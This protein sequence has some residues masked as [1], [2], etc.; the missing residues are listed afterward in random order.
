MS[1]TSLEEVFINTDLSII[2]RL[3]HILSR[4]KILDGSVG[5]GEF[6][7]AALTIIHSIKEKICR[8]LF[9]AQEV[10]KEASF[11]ILSSTL[12]GMEINPDAVK[13]CHKNVLMDN[14]LSSS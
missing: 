7:C 13:N 4:V 1:H 6:L 8:E 9:D 3:N 11:D 10:S 2:E 5:D 14:V 12:Y